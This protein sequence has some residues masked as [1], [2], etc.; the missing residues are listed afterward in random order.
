MIEVKRNKLDRK[1]HR[2]KQRMEEQTEKVK[3]EAWK[4]YHGRRMRRKNPLQ[5]R[6]HHTK[7]KQKAE[8]VPKR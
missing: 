2:L 7:P 8:A 1:G 6:P 4:S 5:R 3:T